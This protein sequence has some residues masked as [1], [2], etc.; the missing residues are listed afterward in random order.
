MFVGAS[1]NAIN[2][3]FK[4]NFFM[5]FVVDNVLRIIYQ[6]VSNP[7]NKVHD[8]GKNDRY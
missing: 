4:N 5:L 7:K 2:D 3:N 8:S 1:I 6:E